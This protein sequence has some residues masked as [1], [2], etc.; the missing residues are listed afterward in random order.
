MTK[1]MDKADDSYLN[2]MSRWWSPIKM[3]WT[4]QTSTRPSL[5]A[6]WVH[7]FWPMGYGENRFNAH[8]RLSY[9]DPF[10]FGGEHRLCD[11]PFALQGFSEKVIEEHANL[12]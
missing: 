8:R 11:G 10:R 4:K 12:R 7:L 9:R 3:L 5:A 1:I 6:S 2:G